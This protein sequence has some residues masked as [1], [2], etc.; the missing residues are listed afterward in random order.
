[1]PEL[2][3]KC[4]DPESLKNM[5]EKMRFDRI[6]SLKSGISQTKKRLL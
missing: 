6:K 2:K 4:R 3:I 1:M 5:I